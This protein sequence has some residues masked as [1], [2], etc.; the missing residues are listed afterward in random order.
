MK[1]ENFGR[2]EKG[3][4]LNSKLENKAHIMHNYY[5]SVF[6]LIYLRKL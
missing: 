5:F 4:V 1:T 2:E 6:K 3:E